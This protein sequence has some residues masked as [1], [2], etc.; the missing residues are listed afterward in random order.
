[1]DNDRTGSR[2]PNIYIIVVIFYE[3]VIAFVRHPTFA[4]LIALFRGA[5]LSICLTYLFSAKR[6]YLMFKSTTSIKTLLILSPS[7]EITDWRS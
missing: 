6:L 5:F 2:I 3:A 7:P 1:M 4:Y